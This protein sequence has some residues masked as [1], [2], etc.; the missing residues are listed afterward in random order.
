M[1]ELDNFR[2]KAWTPPPRP[3]W[4]RRVNEEGN[5]LDLK[6][7]IPLDAESLLAA[8]KRNTGL[9]DF[10]SDDWV[11]PFHVLLRSLE[12]EAHL[13]LMG[14]LLT[15]SDILMY[16]EARLRV[17]DTYKRHPEIEDVELAPLIQICGPG[18]SGTSALQNLLAHDPDNGT[19]LHWEALFPCP[20]PEAATYHTDPRIALA[21]RRMTQWN[22]VTPEMES[23]HEFG[24][25]MPTEIT[26]ITALSFQSVWLIF[27]GFKPSYDAHL[28]TLSPV[29]A[30]SYGR[31]VL[32]LLQWK[33]P[34]KRWLLKSPELLC[35]LPDVFNVFPD[36]HVI[37]MHRDPLKTVSSGVSMVGTILWM[38][39]DKQ[40]DDKVMEHITNP[41]GLAGLNAMVMDQLDRGDFPASR[42]HHAQYLELIA[43]PLATVET[44]YRE[45]GITMSDSSYAAMAAY[46]EAN[47]RESRPAHQ[48]HVGDAEK[49]STERALFARYQER[50]KVK[51][52]I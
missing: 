43:D 46:L 32:K 22:R 18:R 26:Q 52:E 42:L 39:S 14:R 48:Y 3:E 8:A 21:D 2:F 20:P 11:E 30:L 17:E 44:L 41:A 15:R 49:Q 50:F 40:L 47:P 51:S 28:H 35:Y 19:T 24:G 33:N 5:C 27:C 36:S 16:L 13:N 34:R 45:M 31:R 23:I 12:E 10:G 29:T 1:S 9:S 38:R 6:G 4:V 25:A 7:V 37:W